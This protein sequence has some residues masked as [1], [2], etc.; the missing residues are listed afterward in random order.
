MT[1][2]S[3]PLVEAEL[4]EY[5][6]RNFLPP[7]ECRN[8]DQIRSYVSELCDKIRELERTGKHVPACVYQLLS[9]YNARQNALILMDF[10]GSYR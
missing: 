5:A 9:Q 6:S 4:R 10:K 8:L 2:K 7:S 1:A 3:G